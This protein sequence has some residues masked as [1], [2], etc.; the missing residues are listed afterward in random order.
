MSE[1]Q[2]SITAWADE[3]FGHCTVSRAIERAIEEMDE[4]KALDKQWTSATYAADLQKECADVV[5]TLYRVASCMGFDLHAAIDAKMEVN[6]HRR[7]KVKM[8][9]TGYH[10]RDE[11]TK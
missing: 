4:L 6:R 3:T 5:I 2:Q 1:T 7:W 9:G 10:I 8:D 11:V